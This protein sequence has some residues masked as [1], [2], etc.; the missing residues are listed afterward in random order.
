ML[1]IKYIALILSTMLGLLLA[2]GCISPFV[3]PEAFWIPSVLA[4]FFP[5]LYIA[6][7]LFALYWLMSSSKKWSLLVIIPLLIGSIHLQAYIGFRKLTEIKR[8][9]ELLVMSYNIQ[10]FQILQGQNKNKLDAIYKQITSHLTQYGSPDIICVQD[11]TDGNKKFFSEYLNMKY[12]NI[13]QGQRNKTAIF[14]KLPIKNS[15]EIRFEDSYTSCVWADILVG[16]DTIR[17]YNVHLESNQISGETEEIF[18]EY[19]DEKSRLNKFRNMLRKY[20]RSAMQ[21]SQQARKIAQHL[22]NAPY[23]TIFCGDLNDIPLSH[24]YALISKNKTDTFKSN[25][26]GTGSTYAG[27][28]PWLRIDYILCSVEFDILSHDVLNDQAFSDHYAII[29]RIDLKQHFMVED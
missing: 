20:K 17:I 13:Y 18:A 4:L 11:F 23:P 5:Y 1:L 10:E 28:L 29:S 7:F 19:I 14:S 22:E 6:N 16:K 27:S 15:G 24:A 21:R 8:P 25:G 2:I 3:S 12:S 26:K 9:S